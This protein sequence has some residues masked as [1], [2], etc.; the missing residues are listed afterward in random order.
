MPSMVLSTLKVL[1]QS[2]Q[3]PCEVDPVIATILQMR[4][5]RQE[6]VTNLSSK[7]LVTQLRRRRLESRHSRSGI[8]LI[9]RSLAIH[10]IEYGEN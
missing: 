9:I 3:Q 4:R 6:R 2:S 10:L 7:S 1:T 5:L 8:Y